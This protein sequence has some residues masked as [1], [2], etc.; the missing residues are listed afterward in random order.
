[1]NRCCYLQCSRTAMSRTRLIL[2]QP[3]R[4]A[5]STG[6]PPARS[7]GGWHRRRRKLS[8]AIRPRTATRKRTCWAHETELCPPTWAACPRAQLPIVRRRTRKGARRWPSPQTEFQQ[9]WARRSLRLCPRWCASPRCR[10]NVREKDEIVDGTCSHAVAHCTPCHLVAPWLPRRNTFC[11]GRRLK[12]WGLPRQ[13]SPGW[14]SGAGRGWTPPRCP[15]AA[16][17]RRKSFTADPPPAISFS[18]RQPPRQCQTTANPISL[19][20][21][22]ASRFRRTE[23][24]TSMSATLLR[25]KCSWQWLVAFA[26]VK[27]LFCKIFCFDLSPGFARVSLALRPG[28]CWQM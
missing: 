25:R 12:L 9:L 14:W 5:L 4:A 27:V 21:M 11:P 26:D 13:R 17:R 10:P 20:R 18:P 1:M 8:F 28:W 16:A 3:R 7:N 23:S 6:Y 2:F 19:L 22:M 15:S 24:S